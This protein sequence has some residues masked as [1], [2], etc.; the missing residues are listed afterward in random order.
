MKNVNINELTLGDL[1]MISNLN[2][3]KETISDETYELYLGKRVMFM[4]VNYFYE[5]ILSK[6]TKDLVWIEDASIV[7][8]TGSWKDKSY[9]DQ[10]KLPS[11]VHVQKHAMESFGPY[12]SQII[13]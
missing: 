11:I 10:Q 7:Y 8:E 5:G 6:I 4:C 1:K 2:L 3:T 9:H 13:I 12:K